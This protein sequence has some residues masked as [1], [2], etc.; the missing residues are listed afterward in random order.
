MDY[1]SNYNRWLNS[2]KI[3]EETRAQL[4]SM[5]EEE[6]QDAFFKDAEFGTGGLRGLLGPGTNRLNKYTI[7]RVTIGFGLYLEKVHKDAHERGI[8]ISHDNRFFS[9]E[10]TLEAANIL[11]KMGYVVYIFDG[12]RPTPE[13]SYAVRYKN[14]VGGVMITASHNPKEYNGYKVYEHHGCQCV[15]AEADELIKIINS[16]DNEL[17]VT[18]PA[19]RKEGKV[20]TLA[21]D[22]DESYCKKV[23]AIQIHPEL[24]KKDF[25]VVYSPQHGAS[26][27]SAMKVFADAG[28]NIIPVKE[29]A[30]HDPNFG[31]TKSPNPEVE[32]AWELPLEYA[33]K[34]NADVVLMTDPDGDRCGLAYLSSKGTYERLTGNQSGALLM[35]YIFSSYRN[36]GKM[37]TNPVMYDTIVTSSMGREVAKMYDVSFESFLTGFKFIGQRI[38]YYEDLGKGPTFVFGYEESYGCLIAPFVRDKD[39]VQA[40]LLYAEMTLFYKNKG[41]RLDEAFYDLQKRIGFF[42]SDLKTMYFEGMEGYIKMQNLMKDLHEKVITELNGIKVARIEDYLN[43]VINYADGHKEPITGLPTSDV[44]KYVLEDKSTFTIRPSGTEPK[45]KFYIEVVGRENEDLSKKS[46]G[47]YQYFKKIINLD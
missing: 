43:Q 22:V 2:P 27:E 24:D 14:C 3:D 4:L 44:I 46:E 25:F 34:H 10:F 1:L 39:G 41:M 31:A 21:A 16:L 13:L 38:D 30:V 6:K 8:A 17:D 36:S 45:M 35:D 20:V 32:A 40:I 18:I 37:P 9:R 19:D 5:S 28:Y 33:K 47:V 15:P 29:Q 12:L 42:Y 11:A 7:T 23:E 26:Y